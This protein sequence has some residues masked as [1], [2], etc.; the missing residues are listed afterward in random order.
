MNKG[1]LEQF[2]NI[3][4]KDFIQ[5]LTELVWNED[6]QEG[7]HTTLATIPDNAIG[8]AKLVAKDSGIIA[9]LEICRTVFSYFDAN[10]VIS[11]SI[12]DG[13]WVKK[14]DTVFTVRGSVRSILTA[15]RTVLNLIQHLSGIAT[16]THEWCKL[17]DGYQTELLDTR[18]TTPGLRIIEKWAVGIGGAVNHRLGLYDMIMLKDNHID[19]AGGIDEAIKKVKDYLERYQLSIPIVVEA[20]SLQEVESVIKHAGIT[21]ILLDNMSLSAMADAVSVI[22]SYCQT[23][24]SGGI[25]ADNLQA[26][27]ETGV[28]YISTSQLT[29][30][31]KP[32]D[33]SLKI[34]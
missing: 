33:L 30:E 24:A 25:L 16:K 19:Y 5:Q 6:V 32:L 28:N 1:S 8:E 7:D 14:G 29:R 4:Q 9:G 3:Y 12:E 2:L 22:G 18:K 17:L 20:R 23:E 10:L 21:R 27:A 15:E 26:I 31:I 13:S 11:S 34:H